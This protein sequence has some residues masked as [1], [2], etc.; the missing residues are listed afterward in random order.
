MDFHFSHRRVA[1]HRGCGAY[2]SGE[3]M[4]EDDPRKTVSSGTGLVLEFVV[5]LLRNRW[6]FVANFIVTAL[7]ALGISFA[8]PKT[9]VSSV[10]FLPPNGGGGFGLSSLLG[11]GDIGAALMDGKNVVGTNQINSVFQSQQLRRRIIEKAGLLNRYGVRPNTDGKFFIAHKLFSQSVQ[12]NAEKEIGMG[13][14]SLNSFTLEVEDRRPDSAYIIAKIVFQCLD[15]ALRNANVEDARRRREFA[16]KQ[17]ASR[18]ELLKQQEA[19][20]VAFQKKTKIYDIGAQGDATIRATGE[21][22]A[23]LIALDVQLY[24][25]EKSEG[26]QTSNYRLLKQQKLA[27]EQALSRLEGSNRVDILPSLNRT[28]DL[29]AQ[30]LELRR[31]MEISVQVIKLLSQQLE[32]SKLDE[33]KDD[34]PLKMI[35]EPMIPD[36]K[37]RP[38]KAMVIL[39]VVFFEHI[40]LLM[41]LILR[42]VH[43]NVVRTSPEWARVRAAISKS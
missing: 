32:M 1:D 6:F 28:A 10:A 27:E 36:Y 25:M 37:T 34:S 21:I 4:M 43:Q 2:D 20:L 11:G 17:V 14:S 30:Y 7:V 5:F 41:F 24:S 29:G 8:L 42:H 13:L 38:K 3:Q 26:T 39:A 33:A 15:S 9:Y 40:L 19:A 35:S 31:N 16:E 18:F 12:L 23:R 22:R